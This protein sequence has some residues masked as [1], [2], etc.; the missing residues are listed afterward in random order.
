MMHLLFL[1]VTSQSE[2]S[3]DV[4]TPPKYNYR[5]HRGEL[6]FCRTWKC[7]VQSFSSLQSV[8]VFGA[9]VVLVQKRVVGENRGQNKLP[10]K[11]CLASR[12]ILGL[13]RSAT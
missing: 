4:L 13:F 10:K 12:F 9:S 1:C 7:L 11:T 6:L 5:K 8:R 2:S 3:I